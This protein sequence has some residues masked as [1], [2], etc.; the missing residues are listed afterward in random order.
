MFLTEWKMLQHRKKYIVGFSF[1]AFILVFAAFQ[2]FFL[3]TIFGIDLLKRNILP[4]GFCKDCNVILMTIVPLR[5]KS[6]PCYGYIK[7]TAPNLCDFASKSFLFKNSYSQS[8]YTLDNRF[9]IFTSLLP[10]SHKMII[11]L[12]SNLSNQIVTLTQ[13]LQKNGYLTM[14]ASSIGDIN[15]PLDRGLGRGFKLIESAD[16][17]QTWMADMNKDI[18]GDQKFFALLHSY[19]V[20]IPYIPKK[21]DIKK[22]YNGP[23]TA[24]IS[25]NDLCKKTYEELMNLHPDRIKNLI[26]KGNPS[27]DYCNVLTLYTQKYIDSSSYAETAQFFD[28][29]VDSYMSAFSN[30]PLDERRKYIQAFYE[31]RIYELDF[32][33]K[34]FFQYL[35]DKNFLKNTVVIIT[36]DHGEEF[37]EHGNWSH[38]ADLYNEE[39]HVPLIMYIPGAK[40]QVIGKL[41]ESIDIAPSLFHILGIS[42]PAQFQGN[43]LFS[44]YENKYVVT[45]RLQIGKQAI[46]TKDWKLIIN[47]NFNGN[48]MRELYNLDNDYNETKNVIFEYPGIAASMENKLNTILDKQPVYEQKDNQP[49]PAWVDQEE[50]KK[51]I[52]TGYF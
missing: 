21:E 29:R 2:F 6:L 30:I 13:I 46:L 36:A 25:Y 19:W 42:T 20:H 40:P 49:F 32:E 48:I 38:G 44:T 35:K 24:Y 37:Q 47:Q 12:V 34:K 4:E 45:Q 39:I 22:F 10:S 11:P 23:A 43:D 9:S 52:K 33:L 16:D 26:P 51:L 5:A 15:Q 1:I 7:N 14:Y 3:K 17:P 27:G 28:E 8:S 31:A 18:K 41:A 50:R